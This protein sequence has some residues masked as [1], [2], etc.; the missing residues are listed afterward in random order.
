MPAQRPKATPGPSRLITEQKILSTALDMLR[1]DGV[2]GL[3]QRRLAAELGVTPMTLY[4]Y[5]PSKDAILDAIGDQAIAITDRPDPTAPWHAQLRDLLIAIHDGLQ[6]SPGV[7]ELMAT[8]SMNGS[9][10][11]DVRE[12]ILALLVGGGV[13]EDEALV[14]LGVINRFLLGCALVEGR[15][16]DRQNGRRLSAL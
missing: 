1:R 4:R 13:S 2:E 5:F 9:G 12:R 8:R 7:A 11:D 16:R 3:S 10:I 15:T 14:V 6:R